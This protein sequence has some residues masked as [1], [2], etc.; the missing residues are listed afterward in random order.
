MVLNA[1]SDITSSYVIFGLGGVGKTQ[2]AIQ[3]CYKHRHEFDIICWLR[4]ADYETLLESY[5]ELY[6]NVQFRHVT[7]LYMGDE[8]NMD[9]IASSVKLWFETCQDKRWL[10]VFDG[11]DK[12]ERY[13]N[14]ATRA[15]HE[16]TT[17]ANLIPQGRAGCVLVTSRD[18]SANHQL[19]NDGEELLVMNDDDAKTFLL[20]C[21][22]A[23][24]EASADDAFALVKDLGRLP[25]AIEQAGAFMRE[26]GMSIP[27]YRQLFNADRS[28]VL[29]E[30]LPVTHK[31]RYYR[32][33]VSKTWD[34]SIKEIE[35]DRLASAILRI[36]AFLDGT[37]IQRELFYDTR[38]RVDEN[39]EMT[40][41]QFRIAS[42][43]KKLMSY[44][45]VRP[46]KNTRA[47]EI[48]TLVQQVVRDKASRQRELWVTAAAELVSRRFPWGGDINNINVCAHYSSQA[49]TCLAHALD[50]PIRKSTVLPLLESTAGYY[51]ITGQYNDAFNA[52]ERA[53]AMHGGDDVDS[54]D[55]LIGLGR[56]YDRQGKFNEA[57][58]YYKRALTM[59]QWAFGVDHINT[60]DTL[61]RLGLTYHSQ[62]DYDEAIKYFKNAKYIYASESEVNIADTINSLGI[63]Y[64]AQG[65]HAEALACFREAL[66]IQESAHGAG[67][68]ITADTI[69][70]IGNS[71]YH[72]GQYNEAMEQYE[73]ALMMYEK[74]FGLR[75]ISTANDIN[76]IGNVYSSQQNYKQAME[77]FE[78]ALDIKKNAFGEGHVKTADTIMNIGLLRQDEG[79]LESARE[80]LERSYN[81]FRR[82]LGERNP[83]TRQALSHLRA[84]TDELGGVTL[85]ATTKRRLIILVSVLFSATVLINRLV[86]VESK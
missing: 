31:I 71:Y 12:L 75:H 86:S 51:E 33:T 26:T 25:L 62:G 5:R 20:E 73:K 2:I 17:I 10:L 29:G 37:A 64:G 49:R 80:N 69:N 81:I 38:V 57:I 22:T 82:D 8:N 44:S 54:A 35:R 66:E 55:T 43:F 70:N 52:Y 42:A 41:D 21:S 24:P 1:R 68:I 59:K 47:V 85:R 27:E 46:V 14:T 61:N 45:M 74:A 50:P 56:A 77:H 78:R 9:M 30:G 72:Q 63:T 60:A 39:E 53:L 84:V 34:V 15:E 48:H 58:G 13:P 7:G 40:P 6:N 18:R 23:D 3:Y 4:A 67:H 16:L 11:A 36:G 28:R 83:Q 19:A 32:E 65:K 76:N 79:N